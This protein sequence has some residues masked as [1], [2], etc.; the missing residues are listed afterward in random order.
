MPTL[1]IRA[2]AGPRIGVG[3]VMRCLALAQGWRDRGGDAVLLSSALPEGIARRYRNEGIDIV[4]QAAAPAKDDAASMLDVA[5]AREADWVVLDGYDLGT[6]HQDRARQ[7]G[8]R[9]LAIDDHAHAGR[10]TADFIVNPNPHARPELYGEAAG[11]A[12][13][14]PRY[15]ML[16]RE[17][18]RHAP[19]VRS[20]PPLASRLLV[21]LGGSD[22]GRF[23][24]DL[25]AALEDRS[26]AEVKTTIVRGAG[27]PALGCPNERVRILDVQDDMAS[28]MLEADVA[29]AS[30]GGTTWELAFMQ[31]PSLLVTLAENQVAVAAAAAREGAARV[32]GSA[33]H[34]TPHQLVAALDDLRGSPDSR[35]S[36]A[37]AGRRLID[38]AGVERVM[39]R[40][41]DLPI[42]LR[43]ARPDDC[44]RV[45]EWANAPTIREASFH[46]EAIPW[47]DHVRWFS[48]KLEDPKTAYFIAVDG[49]DLSVG[50]VRIDSPGDEPVM[51]ISVDPSAQGRGYGT[52]MIAEACRA[53]S[54]ARVVAYIKPANE[55]SLRA[56]RRAGFGG[57]GQTRI[58]GQEAV[59]VEWRRDAS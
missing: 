29:V 17:F 27:Q 46:S 50:Q 6:E 4:P 19:F 47:T 31:V 18:R 41:L 42:R 56:F 43:A 30:A 45:W 11:R 15:A 14:G 25:V 35:A 39:M 37:R 21:T 1:V 10:Y 24:D 7:S 13:C 58:N 59:R 49:D 9:V 12:L 38:G 20:T 44:R 16:R 32:L 48:A 40:M 51:S 34:V 57:A 54:A 2:D 52:R 23:G 33:E 3:H 8:A 22:V 28:A 36:M 26:L 55:A 5:R 53:H